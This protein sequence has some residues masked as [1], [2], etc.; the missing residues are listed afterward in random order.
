MFY[1][2]LFLRLR[3]R[4][5]AK[6]QSFSVPNI[7]L[8]PK[9]KIAPTVQ[10][11]KDHNLVNQF[12]KEINNDSTLHNTSQIFKF[13]SENHMKTLPIGRPYTKG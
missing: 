5:T 6:G 2:F 9:V 11:W 10:H 8:R 1:I 3:L 7:R 13:L 4:P 12:G